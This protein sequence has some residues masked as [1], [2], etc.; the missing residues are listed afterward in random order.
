[1]NRNALA[2]PR[3]S[4]TYDPISTSE[5]AAVA[6]EASSTISQSEASSQPRICADYFMTHSTPQPT[7]AAPLYSS[8]PKGLEYPM[9]HF[10]GSDLGSNPWA[11]L[12]SDPHWTTE[13]D[14][15]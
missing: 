13:F 15:N 10:H 7:K 1:M 12:T 9:P 11:W 2:Q 5:V 8:K 6:V 3:L 4:S 14:F